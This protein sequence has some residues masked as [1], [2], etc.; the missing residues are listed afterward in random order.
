ML[1]HTFDQH[2]DSELRTLENKLFFK[3]WIRH[4][5]R[6]GTVAPISL[7]LARV[8][9]SYAFNKD[10]YVVE[11]GAGTG[12]LTRALL[13]RGVPSAQLTAVELDSKLCTFLKDTLPA[14]CLASDAPKII[15][16]DAAYLSDL[17]PPSWVGNVETV[18]SSVP[19]MCLAED[20][21]TAIIEA[22]FR[23][24]KPGGKII[25][26]TYNP[27]SPLAFSRAYT[28]ERVVGLWMNIP[29]G[30][31]WSYTK[32]ENDQMNTNDSRDEVRKYR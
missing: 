14:L 19:L 10:G 3:Q 28:Q 6:L 5:G 7:K 12:R 13:E 21:R 20:K 8:A 18:V 29:P 17:I 32:K 9:A 24:L 26:V 2:Y 27:K 31:V 4:P 25:H 22:A 16:G 15:E 30:F 23:V 1:Q 11:I